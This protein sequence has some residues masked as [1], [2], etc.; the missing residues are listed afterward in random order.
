VW[1]NT[2]DAVKAVRYGNAAGAYTVSVEGTQNSVPTAVLLQG[3]LE[4]A[5]KA[6][7]DLDGVVRYRRV[8]D[9]LLV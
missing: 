5:V 4:V 8:A 1:L 6:P 9:A 2:R 3:L 7:L